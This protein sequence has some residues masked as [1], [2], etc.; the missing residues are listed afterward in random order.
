MRLI[1]LFFLL[2]LLMGIGVSADVVSRPSD[3]ARI[4]TWLTNPDEIV[5]IAGDG[6]IISLDVDLPNRF[7]YAEPCTEQA[8]SP[9]GKFFTFFAGNINSG[10]SLFMVEDTDD[11][12]EFATDVSSR[13][14]LGMGSFQYSPDSSQVGYIDYEPI[15]DSIPNGTLSIRRTNALQNIT[16]TA[17]KV[18]AF[19]LQNDRVLF[20]DVT[21]NGRAIIYER[22]TGGESEEVMQLFTDSSSCTFDGAHISVVDDNRL[23]LVL[24][25]SSGCRTNRWA[26]YLIDESVPS[27][28]R[29]LSG[30]T[31]SRGSTA[32]IAAS[33]QSLI[34]MSSTDNLY[35]LYPSGL[36]GTYTSH[37]SVIDRVLL[38]APEPTASNMI[39]PNRN[40]QNIR[41]AN[42]VISQNRTYTAIVDQTAD[43]DSTIYL[44]SLGSPVQVDG[45]SLGDT[46]SGMTFSRDSRYLVYVSGG[47][48]GSENG[49]YRVNVG[50]AESGVAGNRIERGNYVVPMVISP[51]GNYVA[52]GQYMPI[53]GDSYI[54]LIAVEL[55]NG[56]ATE[57]FEGGRV[58]DG[59]IPPETKRRAIPLSWRR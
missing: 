28:T 32:Q 26:A 2:V 12:V 39:I 36:Q 30:D 21:T 13:A 58:T 11:P 24:G 6:E 48:D 57:L 51:D 33:T 53:A 54:D 40:T 56:E 41:A 35:V 5:Y 31:G 10:G 38:D 27:A 4:L 15:G 45:G 17:E 22:R 19:V 29:V 9:D 50:D 43:V 47:V 20:V 16:F 23:L 37:L 42:P 55:S 46:I 44:F 1:R 34:G 49:L 3:S 52:L 14:C 25:Q 7:N 18:A 8:T 59:R